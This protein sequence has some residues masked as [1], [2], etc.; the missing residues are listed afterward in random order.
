MDKK[1]LYVRWEVT[2]DA[3]K[4]EFEKASGV[5]VAGAR[6]IRGPRLRPFG[7]LEF[8]SE[9]A[10]AKA[11]QSLQGKTL[12][13]TP[14]TVEYATADRGGR[15]G[16][17]PRKSA[18]K[19]G[20]EQPA[21]GKDQKGGG[22]S[23]SSASAGAGAGAADGKDGDGGRGGRGGRGRRGRGGARGGRQRRR[24]DVAEAKANDPNWGKVVK[25]TPDP[26]LNPIA[27][28]AQLVELVA[29]PRLYKGDRGD[30][31]QIA[32]L[33]LN[34]DP[35]KGGFNCDFKLGGFALK[36]LEVRVQ[37]KNNDTRVGCRV[38]HQ[39]SKRSR[40]VYL[41][42]S[43]TEKK[44]K[45]LELRHQVKPED[46]GKEDLSAEVESFFVTIDS[47]TLDLAT[48]LWRKIMLSL[49]SMMVPRRPRKDAAT[50]AAGAA[51][52]SSSS[53][54]SSAAASS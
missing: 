48:G 50:P 38:V 12:P 40:E 13:T 15:K 30:A 21:K 46:K 35:T 1:R 47:I 33:V 31:K 5:K 7:F 17:A 8:E 11:M 42:V 44:H 20:K 43:P 37:S 41:R 52:S 23:S 10:A 36:L 34:A 3:L 19:D 16:R 28:N 39:E 24:R 18:E 32:S 27:P 54:S 9:D 4:N 2:E 26:I 14:L 51:A 6:V 29:G 45:F 49:M 25:L 22:R 53:S